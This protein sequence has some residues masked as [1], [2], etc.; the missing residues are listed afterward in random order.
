MGRILGVLDG[1]CYLFWYVS[2]IRVLELGSTAKQQRE[3]PRFM[4]MSVDVHGSINDPRASSNV[5]CQ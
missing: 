2:G 4:L 1:V 5:P 3:I